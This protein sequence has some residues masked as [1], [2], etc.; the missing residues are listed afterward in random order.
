MNLNPTNGFLKSSETLAILP[1]PA[2][3]RTTSGIAWYEVHLFKA[4]KKVRLVACGA[5]GENKANFEFQLLDNTEARLAFNENDAPQFQ[6]ALT[7]TRAGLSRSPGPLRSITRTEK[8][9]PDY[10]EKLLDPLGVLAIALKARAV[11]SNSWGCSS[12]L[13]L[14][15]GV[16]LGAGL[17]ADGNPAACVGAL[18]GGG[19]FVENCEGACA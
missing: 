11:D 9:L 2:D 5:E 8:K 7:L 1:A 15:A 19:T 18:T 3:T 14:G 10:W 17:C 16:A 12:C 4:E 13:L 6:A